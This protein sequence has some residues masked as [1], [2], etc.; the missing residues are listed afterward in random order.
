M[1][2]HVM[3]CDVVSFRVMSCHANSCRVMSCHGDVDI[4][5]CHMMQCHVMSGVGHEPRRPV[6]LQALQRRRP[7]ATQPFLREQALQ[8][9][10]ER[11]SRPESE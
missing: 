2:C 8:V 5:S 4:M 3:S 7:L 11:V 6:Y 1:W 9:R 10:Q